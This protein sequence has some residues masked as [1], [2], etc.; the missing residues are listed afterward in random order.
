[1]PLPTFGI[2]TPALP[3]VPSF[4]PSMVPNVPNI[5][6][7]VSQV[8]A[9]ISS[10]ISATVDKLTNAGGAAIQEL[11]EQYDAIVTKNRNEEIQ[12]YPRGE[13]DRNL[14][15]SNQENS[16]TATGTIDFIIGMPP[17]NLLAQ[18]N[19]A[20]ANSMPIVRIEP[21]ELEF[22]KGLSLVQRKSTWDKYTKLLQKHGFRLNQGKGSFLEMAYIAD[23]FPTDSFTN[24]YGENFIQGITE[25]AGDVGSSLAQMAGVR[26]AHELGKH[27]M[28]MAVKLQ[29]GGS[30]SKMA[31][32][33]LEKGINLAGDLGGALDDFI[34]GGAGLVAE[35][36]MGARMDFPM[37]WKN[38]AFEPSYTMTIRLYNPNPS[39]ES[40]TN[41]YIIGPI[42]AIMLLGLPQVSSKNE[43][44]YSWPFLHR[45]SSPGIFDLDPAYISNI[46]IVKG[47]DQQQ[48]SFTQKLSMV[49][50]RIDFGSLYSSMVSSPKDLDRTRPTLGKYLTALTGGKSA[51]RLS[52]TGMSDGERRDTDNKTIPSPGG[53]LYKTANTAPT[54]VQGVEGTVSRV[55]GDIKAKANG[56]MKQDT[57][58]FY[59]Q[60]PF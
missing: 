33:F 18:T 14:V 40:A 57:S 34:G 25:V 54:T 48:I 26:N 5:G 15:R 55:G 45:I 36:A 56:L 31:G 30:L 9:G 1:M 43:V 59:N 37:L 13:A 19:E 58:G 27:A 46:T 29:G 3:N 4:T 52:S 60:A 22:L 23:N 51:K 17:A 39:S 44:L 21:G 53:I 47:G 42:A 10:G 28:D 6:A 41:K 49:D 32:G 50:V 24:T 38:S 20:I 11:Q 35:M 7:G 8:Q 2:Q 12:A 16:I